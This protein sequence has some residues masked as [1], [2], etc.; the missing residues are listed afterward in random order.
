MSIEQLKEALYVRMDQVDE[1]F[2]KVIYVMT[3]A[4]LKEQEDAKTEKQIKEVGPSSDWQP[5]T[6]EELMVRLEAASAQYQSG[7]FKSIED[8]EKESEEW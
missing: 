3:E 6:E 8:V 4:Y 1:S 7:E 5:M 2:L